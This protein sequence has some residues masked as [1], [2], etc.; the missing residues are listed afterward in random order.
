MQL[1]QRTWDRHKD[2]TKGPRTALEGHFWVNVTSGGE[3]FG[4]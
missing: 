2:R 4:Y 3:G 1:Q